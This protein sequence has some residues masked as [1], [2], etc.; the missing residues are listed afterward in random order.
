MGGRVINE[1]SGQQGLKRNYPKAGV[2]G[3]GLRVPN[4]HY[5]H[6][7]NEKNFHPLRFLNFVV[8]SSYIKQV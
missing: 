5:V 8:C 6:E 7:C 4:S 2:I 3:K 1:S